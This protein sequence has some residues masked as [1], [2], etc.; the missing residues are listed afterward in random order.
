[1]KTAEDARKELTVALAQ[2]E[3][4]K[5]LEL[6]KFIKE[7]LDYERRN[8][9]D[10]YVEKCIANSAA[11]CNSHRTWENLSS[12]ALK[13]IYKAPGQ[14]ECG[15]YYKTKLNEAIK[16]YNDI[17]NDMAKKLSTLGYEVKVN[18]SNITVN[19]KLVSVVETMKVNW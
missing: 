14:N 17:Y 1:M 18:C 3:A 2:R 4:T 7:K 16:E 19:D 13:I 8:F 15:D 5:R 10:D 11:A 12:N 9:S 6:N